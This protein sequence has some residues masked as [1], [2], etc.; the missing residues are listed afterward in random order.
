MKI[1]DPLLRDREGAAALGCSVPTFW[2][3]VAQGIVKRPIK[4]GGISRWPL[5]EIQAVIDRA[6]AQREAS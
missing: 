4:I 3:Y 2:R 5:S 1:V 6:K